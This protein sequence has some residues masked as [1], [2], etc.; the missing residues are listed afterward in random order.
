MGNKSFTQNTKNVTTPDAK[1]NLWCPFCVWK[2]S[3]SY[4]SRKRLGT[5]IGNCHPNEVVFLKGTLPPGLE[6]EAE[7]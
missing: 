7:N 2:Q 5:H 3:D 4:S 6:E 1:K